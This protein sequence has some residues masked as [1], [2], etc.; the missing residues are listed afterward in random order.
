M[1]RSH[2]FL[3]LIAALF[4]VSYAKAEPRLEAQVNRAME[5][6]QKGA[7]SEAAE[8]YGELEPF[9]P[10]ASL[11][12]NLGLALYR[13]GDFGSAVA[14]YLRAVQLE[15][16]DPDMNYNLQFLLKKTT[17]Q[18]EPQLVHNPFEKELASLPLSLREATYL[19]SLGVF[20][21]G[22]S[23][24]F[25]V[26]KKKPLWFVPAGLLLLAVGF[27]GS[28]AFVKWNLPSDW[29]AIRVPKVNVFAGPTDK[30]ATVIFELHAGAPFALL[31]Q[32][33]AWVKIGLSD[34]KTGWVKADQ[35]SVF[36][37]QHTIFVL[38]RSL[39]SVAPQMPH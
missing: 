11:Y 20:L 27:L 22:L 5:L 23:L 36:G 12:H 19:L 1:L 15:P 37:R 25:W 26:F 9:L 32:R 10:R 30:N 13:S 8:A 38:S 28:L 35:V 14:A 34:L 17:D 18:L 4:L 33:D 2:V 16:R 6:Y 31:E 3:S 21:L 39:G 24:S 29:G 7:F